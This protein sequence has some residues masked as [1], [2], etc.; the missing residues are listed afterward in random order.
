MVVNLISFKYFFPHSKYL[1]GGCRLASSS[2]T[3]TNGFF[4]F[5]TNFFTEFRL[6]AGRTI[7]FDVV[8]DA[9]VVDGAI[10]DDDGDGDWDVDDDGFGDFCDAKRITLVALLEHGLT[11]HSSLK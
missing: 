5:T 9:V 2:I 3:G 7:S 1:P 8:V 11:K 4:N 10:D 6:P